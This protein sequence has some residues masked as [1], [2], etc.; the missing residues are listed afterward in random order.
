[1]CPGL[2]PD[3]RIAREKVRSRVLCVWRFGRLCRN[4]SKQRFE[5][6]F[7]CLGIFDVVFMLWDVRALSSNCQSIVSQMS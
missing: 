5:V 7:S 2:Q 6:A 4:Q 3:C 1:M